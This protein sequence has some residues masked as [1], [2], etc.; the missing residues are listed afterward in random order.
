MYVGARGKLNSSLI[1]IAFDARS[2][3]AIATTKVPYRQQQWKYKIF[4][5]HTHTQTNISFHHIDGR[6]LNASTAEQTYQ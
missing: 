3:L 5:I 1:I 4:E 2:T 6:Q